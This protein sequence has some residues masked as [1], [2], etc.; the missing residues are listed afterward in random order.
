MWQTFKNYFVTAQLIVGFY[1][2]ATVGA[3]AWRRD[4]A[5]GV[6]LWGIGAFFAVM[7]VTALI[8]LAKAAY[9]HRRSQQRPT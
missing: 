3:Q 7:P 2:A 8:C 5:L 6:I 1:M 9:D 4:G